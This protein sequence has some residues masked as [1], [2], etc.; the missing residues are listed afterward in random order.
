MD[1]ILEQF[2]LN[3]SFFTEFGLIAIIFLALS[4]FYFKPF[5]A[6][7]E[8]RHQRTVADKAAAEALIGQVQAKLDEYK[9]LI[10]AEKSEAKKEVEKLILEAKKQEAEILA[11]ARDDAKK[12]TQE[13]AEAVSRQHEKLKKELEQEVNALANAVSEKLLSKKA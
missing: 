7:F 8:Q 12:L 4:Q 9:R 3:S 1:V 5:L 6:L 2:G 13:A 10:A 11:K